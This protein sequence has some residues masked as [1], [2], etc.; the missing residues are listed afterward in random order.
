[1]IKTNTQTIITGGVGT[2][3]REVFVMDGKGFVV[4]NEREKGPNSSV[5]IL[6]TDERNL[7]LLANSQV[8]HEFVTIEAL[9][10]EIDLLKH[11]LI[12]MK[13]NRMEGIL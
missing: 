11:L 13:A 9:K 3:T 12:K 1:M 5:R 10:I 4:T 8:T 7:E 6:T 2:L